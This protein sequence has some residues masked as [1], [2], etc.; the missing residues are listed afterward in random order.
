MIQ[1]EN[2]G[3]SY[4]SKRVYSQVNLA[5]EANK[6]YALIGPSGSGKTTL[7]NAIARLENPDQ[8]KVLLHN[9]DI[10]EMKEKDYFKEYLGYVFQNY[11]LV[12]EET[13]WD[14]LKIL[15]GKSEVV[16][17]LQKVGLDESFITSKIYELS[18]GQAQ[19][20]SIA[21]LLLKKAKVILADE[22]TGALDRQTGQAITE[23]LLSLVAA[24]TVVIFATHD[25]NVFEQVD[26][27]I[28]VTQI[29]A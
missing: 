9:Q 20:V 27:I 11:A 29:R 18:G 8:G 28:D 5:F 12:E 25:P 2:L 15:A 17:A 16:A 13:V 24:D 22:P 14:N 19:R 1:L 3:K 21:R 4:G 7:L 6:S 26:Y 10:W 23:L